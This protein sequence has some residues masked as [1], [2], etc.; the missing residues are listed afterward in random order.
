MY[1]RSVANRQT[2]RRTITQYLR[3]ARPD[4]WLGY[5]N[6]VAVT[7]AVL[8]QGV[9]LPFLLALG[10]RALP[11]YLQNPG[12][13]FWAVFGGIITWYIAAQVGQF[14]VW[15]LSAVAVIAFE[16]RVMRRLDQTIFA[17]LSNM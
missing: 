17:H 13:G 2:T 7:L 3:T 4:R 14:I 11:G 10:V 6:L 16:S 8:L 12:Q 5:A 9:L 15:R 1:E